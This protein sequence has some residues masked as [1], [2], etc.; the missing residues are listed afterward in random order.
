MS[1][2]ATL[3][4]PGAPTKTPFHQHRLQVLY[5]ADFFE[6]VAGYA[7][8]ELVD[9]GLPT[10]FDKNNVGGPDRHEVTKRMRFYA[11]SA[12]LR[13]GKDAMA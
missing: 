2:A 3:L 10:V 1:C 12:A 5:E 11:S 6:R 8:K 7:P 4:T 9:E 13:S